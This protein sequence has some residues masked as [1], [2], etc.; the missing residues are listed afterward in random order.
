MKK[1]LYHI[2]IEKQNISELIYSKFYK[3][4][5]FVKKDNYLFFE[6]IIVDENSFNSY[7]EL[8]KRY[9][10][11]LVFDIFFLEKV[12]KYL[13]HNLYEFKFNSSHLNIKK[14]EKKIVYV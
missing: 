10:I 11:I 1:Q 2:L 4:L 14:I 7:N 3:H 8:S 13:V 12:T 5:N 6:K 9:I